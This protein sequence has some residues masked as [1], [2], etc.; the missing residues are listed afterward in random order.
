M[1]A[2]SRSLSSRT[3]TQRSTG[4]AEAE[5]VHHRCHPGPTHSVIGG[6]P[7]HREPN[8]GLVRVACCH[9]SREPFE[10]YYGVIPDRCPAG[11]IWLLLVISEM[12]FH[13]P[14][15]DQDIVE[16]GRPIELDH[17]LS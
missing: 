5:Q 11:S 10:R 14:R 16:G 13:V 9:I 15:L 4:S 1:S 3:L 8:N 17:R 6:L 12:Q 2:S 7:K